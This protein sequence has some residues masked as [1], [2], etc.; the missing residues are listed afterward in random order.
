[1]LE[2]FFDILFDSFWRSGVLLLLLLMCLDEYSAAQQ[3][4]CSVL[5]PDLPHLFHITLSICLRFLI[6]NAEWLQD[7]DIHNY[8]LI[9]IAQF[10][11]RSGAGVVVVV[12]F[13]FLPLWFAFNIYFMILWFFRRRYCCCFSKKSFCRLLTRCLIV[14]LYLTLKNL[15]LFFVSTEM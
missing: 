1:M 5:V 12:I 14:D 2:I 6:L 13:V 15:K 9:F 3:C 4:L 10:I 8:E 7:F 11:H